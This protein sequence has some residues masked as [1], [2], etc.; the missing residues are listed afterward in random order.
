MKRNKIKFDHP[1][2]KLHEQ[3]TGKLLDVDVVSFRKLDKEMVEMETQ[4]YENV[5]IPNS[6]KKLPKLKHYPL[7]HGSFLLLTFRGNKNI[8]FSTLRNH[9]DKSWNSYL[10]KIGQEFNIVVKE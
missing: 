8:P 3:V 7:R 9:S 1:F 5:D 4:Y 10:D 2:T 6:D